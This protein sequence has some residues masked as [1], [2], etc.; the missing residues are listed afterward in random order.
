M[1]DEGIVKIS[2]RDAKSA[3]LARELIQQ[4]TQEAEVGKVYDATVVRLL[5]FGAFCEILPGKE[6]L[7]HI[8]ELSGEYVESVEEH[9][10]VG[11]KIKVKVIEIDDQGRINLSVKQVATDGVEPSKSKPKSGPRGQGRQSFSSKRGQR[12]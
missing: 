8:S 11:D 4:I 5:N 2:S 1:N 6:G 7:C 12:Y 10:K 3:A 9:V